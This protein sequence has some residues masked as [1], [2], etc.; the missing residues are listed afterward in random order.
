[1]EAADFWKI[2]AGFAMAAANVVIAVFGKKYF[3]RLDKKIDGIEVKLDL[4]Q[5]EHFETRE[6]LALHE[7]RIIQLEK[8]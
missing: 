4:R 2:V 8:K 6:K 1:M 7:H 3:D 5:T